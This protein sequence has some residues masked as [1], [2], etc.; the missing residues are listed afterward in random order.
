MIRDDVN[1]YTVRELVETIKKHR[2]KDA[3][4]VLKYA[5]NNVK[6]HP[7]LPHDWSYY[8]EDGWSIKANVSDVKNAY[9]LYLKEKEG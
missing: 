4:I 5:N 7:F 2:G 8:I 3:E 9:L 6:K 1:F